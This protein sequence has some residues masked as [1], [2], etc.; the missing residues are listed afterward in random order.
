M[1][2]IVLAI[3][4]AC[5]VADGEEAV[6]REQAAHPEDDHTQVAIMGDSQEQHSFHP[7]HEQPLTLH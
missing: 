5:L 6:V 2:H 1:S 7:R 4:K 3:Y